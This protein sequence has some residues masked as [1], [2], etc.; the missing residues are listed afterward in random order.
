MPPNLREEQAALVTVLQNRRCA[1]ACCERI[2]GL[3]RTS[4]QATRSSEA[5]KA[6]ATRSYMNPASRPPGSPAFYTGRFLTGT[7]HRGAQC[8]REPLRQKGAGALGDVQRFMKAMRAGLCRAAGQAGC[9]TK[10]K[11]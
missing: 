1:G 6:R 11:E 10:C 2:A 3:E 8:K 5:E 9:N 7:R 4:S